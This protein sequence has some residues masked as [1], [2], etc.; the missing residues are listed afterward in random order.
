MSSLFLRE[1]LD[2]A[3]VAES[4]LAAVIGAEA[5]HAVTVNRTRVGERVSIGNGRGLIVTGPVVRADAGELAIQAELVENVQPASPRLVL[6]QALAKGGRDEMAVQASTELGVD[7]V[8][9]WSAARSVSRWEGAKVA[10]GQERWA[11][12]VREASKQSIRAWLPDVT[13]LFSSKDLERLAATSRMLVLEPTAEL[14]LTE[15]TAHSAGHDAELDI[16]LVVGPEGGIAPNELERL[17]A[18]GATLVRLGSTVL[19][20]STAGAAALSVLSAHLGRW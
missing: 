12:I 13:T 8:I 10:K 15:W 20:T 4:G 11:S 18:A 3:Q 17:Q 19:R 16:V 2:P 14:A 9:P 1:D 6:V 5:K 7:A